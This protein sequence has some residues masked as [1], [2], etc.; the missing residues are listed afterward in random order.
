MLDINV[1]IGYQTLLQYF[2][3]NLDEESTDSI[4]QDTDKVGLHV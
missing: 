2:L 4:L 3:R 1:I